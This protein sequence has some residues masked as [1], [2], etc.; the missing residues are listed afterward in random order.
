MSSRRAAASLTT[1]AL[2][3]GLVAAA[4]AAA[5]GPIPAA[6]DGA[7]R[8]DL[9]W[10]FESPPGF[11]HFLAGDS[12]GNRTNLACLEQDP[13]LLPVAPGTV[14]C[15]AVAVGG[16]TIP[17]AHWAGTANPPHLAFVDDDPAA[18]RSFCLAGDSAK[19]VA[20]T[21]TFIDPGGAQRAVPFSV[22]PPQAEMPLIGS[23]PASDTEWASWCFHRSGAPAAPPVAPQP[24]PAN[25]RLTVSRRGSVTIRLRP[26]TEF[27]VKAP[28]TAKVKL[29]TAPPRSA[30]KKSVLLGS[31]R[32]P[33]RPRADTKLVLRLSR[34]GLAAIKHRRQLR[35][36]IQV[37]AKD[38]AGGAGA[39]F[40]FAQLSNPRR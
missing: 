27:R 39:G 30:K 40:A 22:A 14:V 2:A 4:P 37:T 38:T 25:Q 32:F 31:G 9:T 21:A 6:I 29:Y 20:G 11:F 13:F 10:T 36:M 12:A 8:I 19:A 28:A 18:G 23:T 15:T 24:V 35:V 26:D 16:P 17:N 3:L 34:S 33:L 7:V 1:L 5:D